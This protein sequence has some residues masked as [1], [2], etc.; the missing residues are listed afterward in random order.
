[1]ENIPEGVSVSRLV[2]PVKVDGKK[3]LSDI[4][5]LGVRQRTVIHASYV[6][7]FVEALKP[8]SVYMQVPPDLPIFIK[9]NG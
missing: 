5:L 3:R 1:M 6:N 9:T 7:D 2:Y 4:I 8:E